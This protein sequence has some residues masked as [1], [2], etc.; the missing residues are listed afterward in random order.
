MGSDGSVPMEHTPFYQDIPRKDGYQVFLPIANNTV[1]NHN[2]R[3]IGLDEVDKPEDGDKPVTHTDT[4][5]HSEQN[6]PF[7]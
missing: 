7:S 4:H 3:S 6:I 1:V 5:R 2:A